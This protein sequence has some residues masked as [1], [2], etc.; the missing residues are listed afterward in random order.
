M[1]Q[2]CGHFDHMRLAEV[3]HLHGLA[4]QGTVELQLLRDSEIPVEERAY[5]WSA[6]RF[7]D[8]VTVVD[9][10][11]ETTLNTIPTVPPVEPVEPTGQRRVIVTGC[12]DWLHSGHIRFFEECASYGELTVVVGSDRNVSLLKGPKHPL[13]PETE[14]QFLV[15][16]VRHVHQCLISTGTGWMDAAPEI[17]RI[18]P[19]IYIVNEDGDKPEK[20]E[21]CAARGLEYVVLTRTPAP[22]LTRREST[23]LRGF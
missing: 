1:I 8:R 10:G 5:L 3:V 9:D 15:G 16:S 14:R 2:V 4:Q 13:F 21:F 7:V 18:Q 17:E 22:G 11:E 6:C 20:R 12:Y 23:K 19:D